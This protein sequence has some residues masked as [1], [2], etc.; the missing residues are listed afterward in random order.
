MAGP[1]NV[2]ISIPATFTTD[3]LGDKEPF[4]IAIPP[5]SEIGLFGNE[6]T[7]W[8]VGISTFSRFSP[9][10]FPVTVKQLP[11]IKLFSKSIFETTGTPPMLS[12]STM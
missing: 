8:F 4:S 9:T 3:P 10:V 12:K 5:S 6:T 11:S 7:S 1:L 2:S